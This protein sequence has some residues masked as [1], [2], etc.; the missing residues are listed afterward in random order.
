MVG[1]LAEQSGAQPPQRGGG[2]AAVRRVIDQ[3]Y[4]DT[5][6]PRQRLDLYLPIRG[7]AN[8]KPLPLVV[9]IHGG[10]WQNGNKQGVGIV[11][12]LI[13]RG[14][15]AVVSIGYRLTDEAMWPAQIHDCKAAIRWLRAHAEEY[16]YDAA[17]IAVMGPSAGGHLVAMLGTSAGVDALEG[18]LGNHLDV[19]SAV[20]CV[21]DLYGPSDL[22]TM[23]GFHDRPDSPEAKL[24][25]GPVQEKQDVARAASPIT[26]VSAEDPPFLIIHGTDDRVVPFE[27]SVALDAALDAAGVS[28]TLVPV[29]GGGHGGFNTPAVPQRIDAFLGMHLQ[30]RKTEIPEDAVEAGPPL[31]R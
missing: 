17:R 2:G 5:D 11:R 13:S 10:G 28:S 22:L 31:R 6:N 9:F 14:K 1:G 4:A 18:E 25:G 7:R 29:T 3:P 20:H 27:Q 23:G 16:G 21:V 26:Y 30:D 24:V 12:E 19:S 8:A 15:F